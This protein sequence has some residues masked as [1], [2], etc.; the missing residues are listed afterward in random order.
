MRIVFFTH[1]YPPDIGGVER[2]V[3]GISRALI[4]LGHSVT[5]ITETVGAAHPGSASMPVVEELRVPKRRPFTRLLYWRWMWRRRNVFA[6]SDA[7]HFHDY[8]TFVHWFLPLRW[9]VRAPVY[10]M[11]Y[12]GFD[13]WPIRMRDRAYRRLASWCMDTTFGSG[14]YLRAYYR[15]RI[16]RTSVGAPST[17]LV[18]ATSVGE[19]RFVFV[20]RLAADTMIDEIVRCVRDAAEWTGIACELALVGDG[21]LRDTLRA[22]ETPRFTL[23]F[24][25]ALDEPET[26][27]AGARWIIATGLLAALEGFALAKPVVLPALH[28]LKRDYFDSIPEVRSKA[29]VAESEGELTAMFETLL[30]AE[31]DDPLHDRVDRARAYADTLSWTGIAQMYLDGYADG[32]RAR[33]T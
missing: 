19:R 26:V 22:F 20:G 33:R 12:H 21:P 32:R 4:E 25:G 28:A 9:L 30:R 15:H 11:T 16:D 8:G 18:S 5:V 27:L 1:R 31:S 2:T 29:L 6:S 23:R 10:A 7:L 24:H 13:S 3:R 14:S 17:R